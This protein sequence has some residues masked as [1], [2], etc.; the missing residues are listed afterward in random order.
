MFHKFFQSSFWTQVFL[1][2]LF[3][4]AAHIF[5]NNLSMNVVM[6]FYCLGGKIFLQGNDPYK[7]TEQYG[8]ANSFKYSPQFAL[9]SGNIERVLPA[10]TCDMQVNM[11]TH[12]F[13][14][15]VQD[16]DQ[17]PRYGL[18]RTP[19]IVLGVWTLA[20][21]VIFALGL[22]RWCKLSNPAPFYI[23][24]AFL[25]AML[26]LVIS[27]GV[28]QVNAITIG[29]MLLGL[30]EY[31]DGRYFNAG[32]LLVLAANIKIYPVIFLIA[33]LFRFRWKYL[34]GALVCGIV[35]FILPAFWVGWTFN[36]NMH[37]AWVKAVLDV[38]GAVRILDIVASFERVGLARLGVVLDKVV[39]VASLVILYAYA[40]FSKRMDWRPWAAFGVAAML[41]VSPRSEVF[42]YAMLAPAYLYMFY[43][44]RE[45]ETPF[46]KKFGAIII[47]LLAVVCASCR[48]TDPNWNKSETPMEII[49][50]LC[51][52][53]FWI[54]TGTVLTLSL[55][56]QFKE[57]RGRRRALA[58]SS[59]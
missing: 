2:A 37:I 7:A 59:I 43:W 38:G 26:D 55:L 32:A 3:A 56:G 19:A 51:S 22:C 1:V 50:V 14:V 35:I 13:L 23:I 21:I 53:G 52:L 57:W 34:A 58:L 46:M 15:V 9:L 40:I 17:Q 10:S 28:Y 8:M 36:L 12:G 24:L 4:F 45:S 5:I 49:R 42:T 29:L 11:V 16:H 30:A 18:S 48:F 44:C 27:T 39:F 6:R 47:T 54:F 33:L 41:L 25:A 20:S 31:R